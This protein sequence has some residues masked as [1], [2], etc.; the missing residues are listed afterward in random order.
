MADQAR[1]RSRV[2]VGYSGK[3]VFFSFTTQFGFQIISPEITK[4]GIDRGWTLL[5]QYSLP[6][7]DSFC[8]PYSVVD[9]PTKLC[10]HSESRGVPVMI[11]VPPNRTFPFVVPELVQPPHRSN[12]PFFS[13]LLTETIWDS[14][15]SR[16]GQTLPLVT[17]KSHFDFTPLL[18]SNEVH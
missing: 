8:F 9:T 10:I 6:P 13:V 1:T 2:D 12:Q 16:Y 15:R 3:V 5:S 17:T 11:L 14:N 18:T 4:P 7:H